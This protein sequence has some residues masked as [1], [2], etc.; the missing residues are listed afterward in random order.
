MDIFSNIEA[1]LS[2]SKSSPNV[3]GAVNIQLA[4]ETKNT[5]F[6]GPYRPLDRIL[7]HPFL[8]QPSMRVW[9]TLNKKT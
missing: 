4:H 1:E 9:S 2:N 6:T 7:I 8:F 3:A 5:K